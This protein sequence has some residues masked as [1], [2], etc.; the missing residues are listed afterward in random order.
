ML[1]DAIERQ[2]GADVKEL[3]ES[4]RLLCKRALA[5]GDASLRDEAARRIAAL[6]E[7]ALR[8]LLQ[9]FSA[10]FH[11]VNQ[12]EKHEIVRINRE[13]SRDEAVA[14]PESIDAAVR[15][16]REQGC[17]L[18]EVS[19]VLGELDIQPTLTAHPTEARRRTVLHKQRRI[20][21]LLRELER[22]DATAEES[23]TALAALQQQISLLFA[24][25]DVRT[26]RP[27]IR[28]EIDHGLY[29]LRAGIWSIAPRIDRDVEQA[30]EQHYGA[31]VDVPVFLR[32]R[33]WIGG[34][35][36]GNP[37]V[38]PDV[39]RWALARHRRTALELHLAELRELHEDL[40]VSSRLAPVPAELRAALARH[41]VQTVDEAAA[42]EPYRQLIDALMGRIRALLEH[43]HGGDATAQAPAV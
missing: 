2:A 29:F 26:D 3:V 30:L 21:E 24:T 43:A 18:A 8:W 16:L 20:T 37:N 6:D 17:T 27:T 28:D 32:W 1:G 38:T 34:D 5:E 13:R 22:P 35:R 19:A 9:A 15:V 41:D 42:G 23:H 7:T 33:S 39:T 36:D 31:T 10:F 25:E 4:L 11:L 12:A 40:S 14:R